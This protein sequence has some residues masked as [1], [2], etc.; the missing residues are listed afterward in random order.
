MSMWPW[1]TIG[2]R[3]TARATAT[4][5]FTRAGIDLLE[6]IGASRNSGEMR[7]RTRKNAA[8]SS[9]EKRCSSASGSIGRGRRRGLCAADGLEVDRLGDVGPQVVA[10]VDDRPE[11]PRAGDHDHRDQG[12]D[13]RDEGER[14]LLDLRDGLEDR[15][16]EA[17]DQPDE[18]QR[19]GDLDRHAHGVDDQAGDGVLGHE[20]KLW[21]SDPQIRFQPSTRM[22]S[23]ILKGS[24]MKTGGSIIIPID[25]SVEATTRSMIRNGRKIRNP[26]WN[27]V[28]SSEIV[29]AGIRTVVGTSERSLTFLR[30]ASLTNSAT[31]LV[32]VC[33]HMNS[34][35]GASARLRATV[36]VIAPFCIGS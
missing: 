1:R 16:G 20:W 10:P 31:S 25:I 33:F 29:N 5:P 32:R 9:V 12:R 28:L 35:I 19:G 27:A 14:L 36:C 13:L 23:R 6:N 22:N 34:R 8:T 30:C 17:D 11:H 15:D 7:P 2:V 4:T 18:Q 26:I 24:E 21:T 3:P